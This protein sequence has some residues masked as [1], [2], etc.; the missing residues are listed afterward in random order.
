MD[1]AHANA[2]F[3]EQLARNGGLE[4]LAD[5]DK[6]GERRIAPWRIVRLPAQQQLAVMLGKHD[7]DRVDPGE[8]LGSADGTTARPAA[9]NQ[10][11]HLPAI[12]AEAVTSMPAR[13][14]QRSGE[15]GCIV[16][17]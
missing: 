16:R 5:L 14:A 4:I 2:R 8:V 17:I 1:S 9:A 6:A 15:Q 10:R 13:K 3:L 7:H 11:A 12:G